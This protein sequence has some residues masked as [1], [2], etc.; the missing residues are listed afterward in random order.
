MGSTF[1]NNCFQYY[2]GVLLPEGLLC[3]EPQNF[4]VRLSVRPS[5]RPFV[6]P[7]VAICLDH[8]LDPEMCNIALNIPI[9]R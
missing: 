5:V 1:L 8:F 9:E 7:F 4:D 6:R 2:E 3:R